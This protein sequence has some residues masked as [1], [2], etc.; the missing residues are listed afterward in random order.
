MVSRSSTAC[1]T[2]VDMWPFHS[3]P[4]HHYRPLPLYDGETVVEYNP[5]VNQMTTR[6][7]E[8]AVDFIDRHAY[9]PF[10]LYVPYTQ[11]HVPLGVSDKYAGKSGRGLYADVLMELDWLVGEIVKLSTKKVWLKIP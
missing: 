6:L 3:A 7:T 1:L 5:P 11:P 9:E 4:D 8:K 10:I 2:S